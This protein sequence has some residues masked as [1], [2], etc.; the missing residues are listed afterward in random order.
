MRLAAA[1]LTKRSLAALF[2]T[3]LLGQAAVGQMMDTVNDPDFDDM[4]GS[5]S[6]SGEDDDT[7][8]VTDEPPVECPFGDDSTV[9]FL[10]ACD[11][12]EDNP[13]KPCPPA[14]LQDAENK[15]LCFV[16]CMHT[17]SI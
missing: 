16:G 14:T 13:D 10:P 17:V 12:P 15:A 11:V 7:P 6:G 2:I 4:V 3:L 5:G 1:Q 9:R 8:T